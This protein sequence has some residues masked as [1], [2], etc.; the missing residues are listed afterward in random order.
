MTKFKL[1]IALFI[2]ISVFCIGFVNAEVITE[3]FNVVITN[4]N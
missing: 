4:A 1:I 2:L 3:S